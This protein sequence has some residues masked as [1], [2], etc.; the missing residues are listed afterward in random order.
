MDKKMKRNLFMFFYLIPHSSKER[1]VRVFVCV[2]LC[3]CVYDSFLDSLVHL[4]GI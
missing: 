4:E 1:Q 2:C 3:I